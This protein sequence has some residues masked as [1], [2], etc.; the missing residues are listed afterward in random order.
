MTSN[1]LTRRMFAAV[2]KCVAAAA[3]VMVTFSSVS[4]ADSGLSKE[5]GRSGIEATRARLHAETSLTA[6]QRFAL[7]GLE[8]LRAAEEALQ[9]RWRIN[10]S[11]ELEFLPFLRLPVPEN[12]NPDPFDPAIV[13]SVFRQAASRAEA[14]EKVL[15]NLSEASDFGLQ[16][17]PSDL[18]FDINANAT[19][20]RGEGFMEVMGLALPAD[21]GDAP[22][23]SSF[24]IR[25]DVADVYWLKAYANLIAG[26]SQV[27]LAYDPTEATQ[28][29]MQTHEKLDAL[30][31]VRPQGM[32]DYVGVADM[33]AIVKNALDQQPD[34]A[35]LQQAHGHFLAMVKEN[36]A[37]WRL[38]DLEKDN[39]AEWIPNARQTSALGLEFP[40]QT[41]S[42]W[43]GVL[44]DA[45]GLLEGRLLA[46]YWQLGEGAGINVKQMFLDPRPIDLLD[47]IQG[48]DALPYAQKGPVITL[49][50]WQAFEELVMGNALMYAIILN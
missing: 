44:A 46:P 41:G 26:I 2:G 38:V 42:V 1:W 40:P 33:F 30:G 19:R 4:A 35:A 3:M 13:A 12:T 15:K 32:F 29:V 16:I 48:Q 8:I 10:M 25:F 11:N 7:A 9:A 37:F 47:W 50:S 18:W 39:E 43:Q 6:D 28:T 49:A 5:V 45:E 27:V 34:K 23:A 20:D 24:P 36:R 14:A 31:S 22:S 21:T 17:D